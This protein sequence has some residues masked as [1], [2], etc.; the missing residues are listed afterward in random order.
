MA[1]VPLSYNVRSLLVRRSATF[2]TVLGIGATVAVVSG[3]LALQQGFRT[4]FTETG[5]D[6]VVVFLRPGSTTE[7]DSIFNLERTDILMKSLPEVARAPDG[8]FLVSG[9]LYLAVRR[10]K[11]D[12]GETNVPV[13]GV[14]PRSFDVVGDALRVVEGRRFTPGTDE[15]MVGRSLVDRIRNCHVGDTIWFNVTP[16][17]VVGVFDDPGPANSEIWGD[18]DRMAEALKR[19]IFN[20][21]IARLAPG[22]DLEA[23]KERMQSDPQ[24]PCKVMT[25]REYLTSQ[26]SALSYVLIQLGKL[27]AVIMGVAAVFTATNTMLAAL[28]ARTH[29]IGILLSLG[30]RP[31]AI[32]LSFLLESVL[33]GLLGG[34]AGCLMT[35]PLDRVD[36]GAMNFQTFTEVAFAFRV[37]PVVLGTAV[38]FSL[39]LGLAGGAWPAWR[40]ARMRPTEALRRE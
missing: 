13:R 2:L 39:G 36:T 20:R 12:G 29:E 9:E 22:T 37:T 4:L 24:V 3:V 32:F 38:L 30:F 26:T 33:L 25:E 18:R 27:L 31:I 35:L 17:K 28:A 34:V 23:L 40:A 1:L 19:P 15:V 7:G 11:T 8:G 16:F 10:F 21:V 5:S 6:D 14:Q